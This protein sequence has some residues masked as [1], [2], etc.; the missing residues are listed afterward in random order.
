VSAHNTFD[1]PNQ[2]KP[3]SFDGAD[4]DGDTLTVKLPAR[5]VVVLTLE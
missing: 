1:E 5:S 2:V 4:I 3:E